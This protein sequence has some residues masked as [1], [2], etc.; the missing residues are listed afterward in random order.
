[1]ESFLTASAAEVA[2][3]LLASVLS[4]RDEAPDLIGEKWRV[5][6][7][8]GHGGMGTVYLAE[9]VDGQFS[10]RVAVKLIKRGMDSDEIVARFIRERQI[11]ARLNHPNIAS[12]LDGGLLDDGRPFIVMEHVEGEPIDEFCERRQLPIHRRLQLFLTVCGAVQ[13]AHQHLVVH[14]DLKPS[15]VLVT[16]GGQVKLLDFGIAKL[17]EQNG[18]GTRTLTNPDH[19]IMTP[20]Y[21]SPEMVQ[22]ERVTTTSDVYQLGLILYQMLTR[23]MP[24]S[25]DRRS[26]TEFERVIV[27]QSPANASSL[28]AAARFRRSLAGDLDAILLKTLRKE[29]H[30]RYATAEALAADI[31]RY[32]DGLP[33]E[34]RGGRFAYRAEKFVRRNAWSLTGATAFAVLAISFA[35]IYAIRIKEERDIARLEAAKA[36]QSAELFNRFFE[37]WNPDAADRDQIS[38]ADLLR[39]SVLRAEREMQREPEVQA[40]MLSLLGEIYTNIGR[41]A[42]A[43]SLL[44][45]ALERQKQIFS[46]D[47]PDRAA[48]LSRIG[49]LNNQ[50][51]RYDEAERDY[52]AALAMYRALHGASHPDALAAQLGLASVLVQGQDRFAEAE[53]LL[54]ETLSLGNPVVGETALVMA[55]ATR[56]LGLSLFYQARYEEAEAILRPAVQTY[57][58]LFGRTHPVTLLTMQTLAATV[59]DLGKV[60]ES[61]HLQKEVLDEYERVYGPDHPNTT[62][63]CYALAFNYDRQGAFED[64]Y[65]T[66][67][68]AYESARKRHGTIHPDTARYRRLLGFIELNRGVLDEA[69]THLRGALR[70]YRASFSYRHA[71]EAGILNRLAYILIHRGAADAAEIYLEA[72]EVHRTREDSEPLFATYAPHL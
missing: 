28:V 20:E 40:S 24:Y 54:R 48:T 26:R 33:V 69:E 42:S 5:L 43:D 22:G 35:A 9:R 67:R 65:A 11:L 50:R 18:D 16:D 36:V 13:H 29:H 25:F 52:E 38:A 15:N 32:L 2:A 39:V 46:T 57:T 14:R 49:K 19:N 64:A 34:A 7:L 21:A 47:H 68:R 31:Q 60:D 23:S 17:L 63:A 58:Q 12:I 51:G 27:H 53:E 1:S 4:S 3:P 45:I 8:I 56:A 55:D 41:F 62:F 59:R 37:S 44:H 70:A 61:V 66:A 6:H 30:R 10:Q 72:A 71:D